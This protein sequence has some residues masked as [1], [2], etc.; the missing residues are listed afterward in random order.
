MVDR[1]CPICARTD[2]SRVIHE[3]RL[4]ESRLDEFAYA[5]R[6]RPELMHHRLL[7]CDRCDVLYA[8]PAPPPE[9][10][11]SGYEEAAYDSGTEARYAARTYR[12][13]LERFPPPPAAPRAAALDIGAGDGAFLAEL[14]DLGYGE[15]IGIE[16][17][18]APV[19]AAPP[20]LAERIVPTPI[21]RIDL[22][23]ESLDLVTCMATVEHLFDPLDVL[24]RSL[25][26]LRPG[27]RFAMTCHD[28]TGTLN[29]AAGRRSPIYDI[30]H[31]QLLSPTS[32]RRLL[33]EAGFEDVRAEPFRNRYPLR[34]WSRL[35][36]KP[37]ALR[38]RSAP[39]PL[40]RLGDLPLSLPAGNL[41]VTGTR[42]ESIRAL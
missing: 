41:F 36:P 1:P 23:P 11:E 32:A 10:L 38:G 21:E 42:P 17:S 24:Q 39:G 33:T 18:R 7:Q 27:G 13:L 8:S 34:Y 4:D 5:S 6:K 29:R 25:R 9:R 16:P 22:E 14:V 26:L 40:R 28:R 20:A 31:L 37:A 12:R 3:S 35:A 30:E 2:H 15:A 19:E